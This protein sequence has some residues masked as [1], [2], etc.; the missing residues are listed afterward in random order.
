LLLGCLIT[1]QG[2]KEILHSL[3]ILK[4]SWTQ[5][6]LLSRIPKFM[7]SKIAFCLNWVFSVNS[8]QLS[9]S[10]FKPKICHVNWVFWTSLT[11]DQSYLSTPTQLWIWQLQLSRIKLSL[12]NFISPTHAASNWVSTILSKF[13]SWVECIYYMHAASN[14]VST[15]LS[16]IESSVVCVYD[17]HAASNWVST[18]LSKFK[19]W[20]ECIYYMHAASNWV[21]T[22]LSRIKSLVVCVYDMHA[23][24]N[25]VSTIL[26]KFKSWVE[27]IYYCIKLGVY[28]FIEFFQSPTYCS[29][30]IRLKKLEPSS[31]QENSS[32]G[33]QLHQLTVNNNTHSTS[34]SLAQANSTPQVC[35]RSLIGLIG[36]QH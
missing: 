30:Y 27:C 2:K 17:M 33:K 16:R 7:D 15:I 6:F 24:S 9:I 1:L 10:L 3:Q 25:W 11:I 29:S 35:L 31:T 4:S 21:S 26:W 22:I 34:N 8:L 13:K 20:V 19:S 28:N 23:A 36:A 5:I 12:V 18:I 14:W 32:M